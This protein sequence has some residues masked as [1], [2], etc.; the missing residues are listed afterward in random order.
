MSMLRC[1][2]LAAMILQCV[3]LASC[4]GSSQQDA[5]IRLL[6][7]SQDY[8]S[9]D[10]YAGDNEA[11]ASEVVD[12]NGSGTVSSYE[13]LTPES[14]DLYVT[15]HGVS[16]SNALGST[17]ESLSK[18]TH[19]TYVAFGNTGGFGL[20][21][22]SE[23]QSA[24]SSGYADVEVLNTATDA[25]AIDVYLTSQGVSL[26][27][28]SPNFGDLTF[29]KAST[30]SAIAT[31]TY[32]L[33]VTGIG[34]KPDL[35]LDVPGITL[36]NEETLS[37]IITEAPGGYLVGA[38][39]LP[40]QG[41]LTAEGNPNARVRAAVGVG[42]G[43]NVDVTFGSTT[44]LS[45]APAS[46]VGTYQLVA[47]GT[48]SVTLSV[49]GTSVSVPSQTLTSGQDYT[50][51][52][53]SDSSSNVHDALVTD[54]NRFA[55]SGYASVRLVNLMSGLA[56]PLSLSVDYVPIATDVNLGAASSYGQPTASTT[57]TLSVTDASTS[58]QIFSQANTSLSNPDVYSLFMFG[59][60]SAT[61]TGI[62]RQDR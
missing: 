47:S 23:D 29:G 17:N 42:S 53:W 54:K 25:G 27:D 12:G 60:G 9:L 20:L 4:G 56:D 5:Q 14:Y 59:G 33:R 37:I 45:A 2:I 1:G 7:L 44:L 16:K 21:E 32:E 49:N 11:D 22:I 55:P 26:N 43:S 52:V 31:G 38:V 30:F 51:L 13:G 61:V 57:A 24:P 18:N 36:S 6:N 8:A 50:F 40:Q 58:Q 34:N 46:A 28:V 41:S 35:R 15:S 19:R 62:L 10:L 39:V 3:L 48:Q